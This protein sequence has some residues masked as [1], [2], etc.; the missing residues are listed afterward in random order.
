MMA[1]DPRTNITSRIST[2]QIKTPQR[3]RQ[4]EK[5][6]SAIILVLLIVGCLIVLFP[7]LSAIIWAVILSF[8]TWPLYQRVLSYVGERRT[9]LA[10]L[11][12][13]LGAAIVLVLPFVI[14][15]MTLAD[16]VKNLA[17]VTR[18]WMEAGPPSPPRW[19]NRIPVVGGVIQNYWLS[20]TGDGRRSMAEFKNLIEPASRGC[21]RAG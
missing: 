21:W 8:T 20:F 15:G 14:V 4:L 11:I 18:Q 10:A 3:E 13:T 1:P 7:F 2:D 5:A 6:I 9:W 17:T 19:L 16:D 12:M